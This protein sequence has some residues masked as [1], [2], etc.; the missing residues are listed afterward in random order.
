MKEYERLEKI[1]AK[2]KAANVSDLHEDG[3]AIYAMFNGLRFQLSLED[4]TETEVVEGGTIIGEGENSVMAH[5]LRVPV[6]LSYVTLSIIDQETK[7]T[8]ESYT[9]SG[10]SVNVN[11]VDDAGKPSQ[12]PLLLDLYRGLREKIQA[13]IKKQQ[14]EKE[15]TEISEGKTKLD[16]IL[17]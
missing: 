7:R 13:S 2:I 1:C 8:I 15:Q 6:H 5:N 9:H 12:R 3:N 14:I 17:G 16:R 4:K 10:T 11:Y